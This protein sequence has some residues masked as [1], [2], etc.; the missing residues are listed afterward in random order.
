VIQTRAAS[1]PHF[2]GYRPSTI[3]PEGESAAI[4]SFLSKDSDLGGVVGASGH[5]RATLR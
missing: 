2:F 5:V 1:W 3:Q 4:T